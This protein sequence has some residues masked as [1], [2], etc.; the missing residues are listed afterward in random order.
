MTNRRPRLIATEEAFATPELLAAM[1]ELGPGPDR[2]LEMGGIWGRLRDN[3][4]SALMDALLDLGEGRLAAMDAAG[5]DMH[6]L[7]L[8][9]PG[10]QLLDAATA[11][12]VAAR[13]NDRLAAAVARH[14][15]RFAGLAAVAPQDP[16]GAAAEIERAMRTLRL[17][18][19]VINSHTDGE[20]LD[21]PGFEPILAAAEAFGAAIYLHPRR[22]P[23]I[24]DAVMANDV[25]DLSAGMWGFAAETSLHAVR[26]IMSGAFD[27]HP[28]LRLVLG[29]MG[30][31]LPFWLY[32]LDYMYHV[33]RRLRGRT[34]PERPPSDYF[35]TNI[36][37]TTSGMNH[38]PALEY[39]IAVLG[40][41]NLMFAIDYPYQET[42]E[43]A[44]FIRSAR[45]S[46]AERDRI[47]FAN[48]ERIFHIAP[49]TA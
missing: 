4:P 33:D 13:S 26:L 10:V 41:E 29:H 46:E 7:S 11:T 12:E 2:M 42:G 30:E 6:L 49:A 16:A 5:I 22:P 36:A 48:A 9:S 35:R 14:P 38:L 27:R 28:G 21:Q 44:A 25:M 37:I 1:R 39:C 40:T 24:F 47:F 45:L 32:R 20:Y 19:V 3:A 17:N 18:G 15:T 23:A 8:T 31:G 34:R 43:A